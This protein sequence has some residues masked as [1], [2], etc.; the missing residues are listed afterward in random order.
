MSSIGAYDSLRVRESSNNFQTAIS[1]I[2]I[3][4]AKNLSL[5]APVF[6]FPFR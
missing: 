1:S 4:Q 5:F 3:I 2:L 6:V